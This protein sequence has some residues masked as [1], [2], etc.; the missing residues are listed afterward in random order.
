MAK[1]RA[2]LLPVVIDDTRD[3][4]AHVPDSFTEVQWTRLPLR[5]AQGFQP[6]DA[7]AAFAQRVKKL[8]SCSEMETRRPRP[9]EHNEGAAAPV[10]NKSKPAWVWMGLALVIALVVYI[11]VRPR[12]SPEQVVPAITKS[13]ASLSEAR[14]LAA[15]AQ[16]LIDDPNFTRE[17]Y[18]LADDLCRRALA[19]DDSDAEIWAVAAFVSEDMISESY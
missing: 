10:K 2:F 7:V 15:Q 3:A 11:T 5:Q 4:E 9:E 8:L 1:G 6:G 14:K 18:R 12:H 13:A 16:A 17:N 19:L